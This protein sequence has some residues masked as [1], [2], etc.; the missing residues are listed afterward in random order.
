MLASQLDQAP[1]L[2]ADMVAGNPETRVVFE[3]FSHNV[4]EIRD[5]IESGDRNALTTVLQELSSYLADQ[6]MRKD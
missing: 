3:Q 1:E 2:Y 4:M 6:G 5:A